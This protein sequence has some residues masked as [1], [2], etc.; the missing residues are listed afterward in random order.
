VLRA[1]AAKGASGR[2]PVRA[3]TESRHRQKLHGQA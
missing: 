3:K 2:E 1:T